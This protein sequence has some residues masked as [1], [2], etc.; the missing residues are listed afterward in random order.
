MKLN[1]ARI[2]S[3]LMQKTPTKTMYFF[4]FFKNNNNLEITTSQ[5]KK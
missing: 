3:K 1:W 5:P 4:I 2:F